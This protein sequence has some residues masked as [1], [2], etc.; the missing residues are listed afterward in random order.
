MLTELELAGLEGLG[1][2][3]LRRHDHDTD[4][5]WPT[6]RRLLRPLD[7]AREALRWGPDTRHQRRYA[8]DAVGLVL[9]RCGERRQGFWGWSAQDW[10]DLIGACAE[11]FRRPWPGRIDSGVRPYVIAYAWLLGGFTDFPRIGRFHR[12]SLAWRVF[13]RQP[14]EDAVQRIGGVLTSWGYRP[15]D[16]QLSTAVCQMLLLNRSPLLPDLTD[17]VLVR[18]RRDAASGPRLAGGLHGIH[19]AVAALGH[20]NPPPAP[21]YGNG[22]ATI[23]GTA[24]GWAEWVERWHSTSTLTPTFAASTATCCAS[25]A[26]GWPPSTRT[27]PNPPSGPGR[28]ARPGWRLWTE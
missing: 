27:S 15:D 3:L 19:R 10:A 9:M 7:D 8:L 25:S 23:E 6:I 2:K 14:V 4:A 12:V 16:Q 24:R 20:V 18:L 5:R 13:G 11:E 1:P 26:G 28:P 22:P 21:K 17:E